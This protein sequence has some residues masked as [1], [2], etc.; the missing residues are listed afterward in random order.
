LLVVL[1]IVV[2]GLLEQC[3]HTVILLVLI[4]RL[5][6]LRAIE[7][8]LLVIVVVGLLEQC[9]HTVILLM[10]ILRLEKLCAIEFVV[11]VAFGARDRH[12]S[13]SFLL[14]FDWHLSCC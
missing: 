10:L 8:I 9:T 7:V 5:E 6:K 11:L 3:T 2:V 4:L 12:L 1:V 14:C 13:D